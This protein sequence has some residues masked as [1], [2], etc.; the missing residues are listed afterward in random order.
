MKK[1]TKQ[2][3]EF[4]NNVFNDKSSENKTECFKLFSD[5][6]IVTS[7]YVGRNIGSNFLQKLIQEWCYVMPKVIMSDIK[8][9]VFGPVVFTTW[10]MKGKHE[11]LYRIEGDSH[12]S[13][14]I[15]FK[16]P[17]SLGKPVQYAGEMTVYFERDRI[18]RYNC[19]YDILSI[20]KQLGFFL[21]KE[22]YPGQSFLFKDRKLL[23]SRLQKHCS[24]PITAREVEVLSLYIMGFSAKQIASCFS[25]SFR[26]VESHIRKALDA[27]EAFN[28]LDCL[29]KMIS[30]QLLP[31]WQDLGKILLSFHHF[32]P[33]G[34]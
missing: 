23:I 12:A 30:N 14:N 27:V 1:E 24:K 25:I 32:N 29:E 18:V 19:K 6:T 21:H 33:K 17:G 2:V 16:D 15:L 9:E 10:L 34:G 11:N 26:T 31:L 13:H 28:K 20:Y 3:Y 22:E 7:P 8:I 4:L 5:T